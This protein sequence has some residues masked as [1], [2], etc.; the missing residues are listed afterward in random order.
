MKTNYNE[1]VVLQQIGDVLMKNIRH[2]RVNTHKGQRDVGEI[3]RL[4]RKMEVQMITLNYFTRP[5]PRDLN[6]FL[7]DDDGQ[8]KQ[9]CCP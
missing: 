1:G 8:T 2:K 3:K 7:S 9:Y 5:Q 4:K 6:F